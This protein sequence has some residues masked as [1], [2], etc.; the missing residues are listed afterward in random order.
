MRYLLDPDEVSVVW[1]TEQNLHDFFT[2]E[3]RTAIE[4]IV[5]SFYGELG[6]V[7]TNVTTELDDRG[8]IAVDKLTELVEKFQEFDEDIVIDESFVR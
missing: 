7:V 6:D 1:P 4:R 2:S 3:A 8:A 5:T